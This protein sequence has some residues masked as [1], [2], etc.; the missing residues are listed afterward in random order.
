MDELTCQVQQVMANRLDRRPMV[1][2]RQHQ[3]LEPCHHIEGELP[4]E[5]V[6]PVGMEFLRGQLL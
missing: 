4:D 1:A 6:G 5:E 3:T 2:D